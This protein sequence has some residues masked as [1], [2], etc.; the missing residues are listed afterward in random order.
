MSLMSLALTGQF[1]T[2]STTWEALLSLSFSFYINSVAQRELSSAACFSEL[3]GKHVDG[4][5]YEDRLQ[6]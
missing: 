1:L 3:S 4:E 6:C 5:L 2:T